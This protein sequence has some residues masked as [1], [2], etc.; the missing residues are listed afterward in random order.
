MRVRQQ[1]QHETQCARNRRVEVARES[2]RSLTARVGPIIA[3]EIPRAPPSVG[4]ER[5][6]MWEQ[7]LPCVVVV[8]RILRGSTTCVLQSGSTAVSLAT[9]GRTFL[10]SRPRKNLELCNRRGCSNQCNCRW[11]CVPGGCQPRVQQPQRRVDR[12]L[13]ETFT[14]SCWQVLDSVNLLDVFQQHFLVLQNCPRH[15]RG[16]FQQAA[17]QA[18]EL[19][20]HAVRA[21]D[22]ISSY[23]CCFCYSSDVDTVGAR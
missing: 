7:K 10:Q 22:H 5:G 18:L 3:D 9:M 16:R 1:M 6:V 11:Q 23:V 19:R 4:T 17:R 12:R 20:S 8:D 15:V 13:P 2:I 14:D 21:R